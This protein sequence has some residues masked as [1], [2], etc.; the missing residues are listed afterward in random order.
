MKLR[1]GHLLGRQRGDL[2]MV[3]ERQRGAAPPRL[4]PARGQA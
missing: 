4:E 2:G 1:L 3:P